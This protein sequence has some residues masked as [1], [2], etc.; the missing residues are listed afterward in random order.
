MASTNASAS[1]SL[2]TGLDRNPSKLASMHSSRSRSEALAVSATMGTA[3]PRARSWRVASTP[4]IPGMR[5]KMF[6]KILDFFLF[7]S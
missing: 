7:F 2:V 6:L 3:W 1:R 4:P 5:L